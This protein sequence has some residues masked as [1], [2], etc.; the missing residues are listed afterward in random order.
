MSQRLLRW[1]SRP[2]S[3]RWLTV[4]LVGVYVLW[5]GYQA[6]RD[7]LHDFGLYYIAASALRDGID[8]Y[9]IGAGGPTWASLAAEYGVLHYAP[10]YRY[11]PLTAALVI[12]LTYLS[13]S[14]AGVCWLVV[15]AA[16]MV[17]SAWIVGAALE[18]PWGVSFTLLLWGSFVPPLTTLHAGQVNA[19]VLLAVALC[20]WGVRAEALSGTLWAGMGAAVGTM[21]KLVPVALGAYL[22]WRGR[23]RSVAIAVVIMIVVLGV[24][25]VTWVPE[26]LSSYAGAL[27]RLGSVEDVVA[28]APNQSLSGM[29][30]RALGPRTSRGALVWVGRL[31]SVLCLLATIAVCW[32]PGKRV[33][34]TRIG[35]ETALIVS[36][37][38]LI[39]PYAWYHQLTLLLVPAAVVGAGLLDRLT[40]DAGTVASGT[41]ALALLT[42]TLWVL[43]DMHGLVWHSLPSGFM[44]Q[45]LPAM[46]SCTLW[47]ILALWVQRGRA[48]SG[49]AT[50]ISTNCAIRS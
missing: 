49:D 41:W 13:S 8:I 19:L 31:L 5:I 35:L 34:T 25:S 7:A 2:A 42:A 20:Y 21:L 44:I 30:A 9:R 47:C 33:T 27:G 18:R 46:L 48:L 36:T 12:P 15:S 28:A 4:A 16:A 38:G 39:T 29:A 6:H 50:T 17:A 11:P 10:P 40:R 1:L 43:T 24:C 14:M 22:V 37:L 45:S 32:P 23:W 3:R 26:L